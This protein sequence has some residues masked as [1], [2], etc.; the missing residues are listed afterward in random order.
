MSKSE[1]SEMEVKKYPSQ[2]LRR[3]CSDVKIG[4]MDIPKIMDE[5]LNI[6]YKFNGIG[7]AGPQCGI[8]KKIVVIDLMEEPKN[9]YKLINP[10]ITWKS[11]SIVKSSEGC[12]SLPGVTA[13]ISRHE[14]VSVKYLDENFQQCFLEKATGLMAICLQHEIDHLHGKLY[15]DRLSKYKKYKL[16]REFKEM[17]KDVRA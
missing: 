13:E 9:I 1:Q 11:K 7:L 14:S 6:I 2:V 17:Q 12:L 8:L 10:E 16:V 15:I 4:D 3:R 5:M